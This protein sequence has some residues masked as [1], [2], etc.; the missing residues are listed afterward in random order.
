MF[1]DIPSTFVVV[2]VM[3]RVLRSRIDS[4]E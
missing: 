4:L 2:H 1:S 3:V